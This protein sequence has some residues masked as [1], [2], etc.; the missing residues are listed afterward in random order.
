MKQGIEP[1]LRDG[2]ISHYPAKATRR[3]ELLAWAAEQSLGADE[4]IDELAYNER[5]LGLTDDPATLRRYLVEAGLVV[6]QPGGA[7]YAL[8]GD[9]DA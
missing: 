2:R 7:A 5:L 4:T 8:A 9:P 6:R 3:R 1:F